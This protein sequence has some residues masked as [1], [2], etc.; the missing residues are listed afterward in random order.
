MR[1][2]Y[3]RPPKT[4]SGPGQRGETPPGAAGLPIIATSADRLD[5]EYRPALGATNRERKTQ[6][7]ASTR[8]GQ[9]WAHSKE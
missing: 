7:A 9:V 3:G 1:E 6:P 8:H 2:L 5:K 4:H